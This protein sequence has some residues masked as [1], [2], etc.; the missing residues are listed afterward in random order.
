MKSIYVQAAPGL[1]LPIQGA[2]QSYIT[3]AAPIEVEDCHYYRKALIDGDL[4]EFTGAEWMTYLG[5]RNKAEATAA[6][7]AAKDGAAN[8]V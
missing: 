8:A 4:V 5:G 7:A 1:K 3:D 2:P 6:K